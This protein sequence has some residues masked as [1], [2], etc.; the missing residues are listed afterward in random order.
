MKMRIMNDDILTG[1]M[2]KTTRT[3][4]AAEDDDDETQVKAEYRKQL[5]TGKHQGDFDL[6]PHCRFCASMYILCACF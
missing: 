3:P 4:P 5:G 2:E 1:R 6:M